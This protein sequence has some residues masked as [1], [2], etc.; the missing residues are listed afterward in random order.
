MGK[1]EE[2]AAGGWRRR[3]DQGSWFR[4][5]FIPYCGVMAENSQFGL[6]LCVERICWDTVEILWNII[7]N[8]ADLPQ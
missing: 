4:D 6:F 7:L 8:E 2:V 1:K 3:Q 5:L